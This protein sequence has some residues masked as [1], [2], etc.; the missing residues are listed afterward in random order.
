MEV[1]VRPNGVLEINDARITAR[2]F[3]GAEDMYNR[4]GDRNFL[5]LFDDEE[6]A[7]RLID[8]GWNIRKKPPKVEGGDPFIFMK[9]KVAFNDHGPTA[10]LVSGGK[11]ILLNESTIHRLDRISISRVDMD[12]RPYDWTMRDGKSGRSAYLNGIK[13]IQNID[14]F[15][16]ELAEEEYPGEA[17]W[18]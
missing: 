18:N 11:S 13:V 8:A 1:V 15:A 12:I 17:P 4:E 7:D 2:N 3:A 14:R 6:I 10:V 16:A 9:I 5:L